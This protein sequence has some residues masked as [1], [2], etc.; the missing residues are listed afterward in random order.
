MSKEYKITYNFF[1]EGFLSKTDPE[2]MSFI[3]GRIK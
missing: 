1:N 3:K 2:L